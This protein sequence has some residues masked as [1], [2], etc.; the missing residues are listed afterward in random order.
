MNS[1]SFRYPNLLPEALYILLMAIVFVV[2]VV[3]YQ[4][5]IPE[6]FILLKFDIFNSHVFWHLFV[7]L[8][9]LIEAITINTTYIKVAKML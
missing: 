4:K 3:V 5:K 6:R 1:S 2:G 7:M 8:G 9:F